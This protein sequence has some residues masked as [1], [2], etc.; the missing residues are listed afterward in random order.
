[1]GCDRFRSCFPLFLSFPNVIPNDEV[2]SLKM[3]HR[4][5]EPLSRLFLNA[6]QARHLDQL[7]TEH[8]FIS[9]QPIAE[10]NYLPLFIGFVT[11]DQPKAMLAFFEGQRPAFKRRA[12]EFL[13]EE[14]AATPRQLDALLELASR[15]YRRPLGKKE[16]ADLLGL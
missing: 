11:Q 5:D 12:D 9:R 14:E 1:E 15:A 2:V 16:K 6:E 10:N 8:R 13:K 7:W 3:F 4:E